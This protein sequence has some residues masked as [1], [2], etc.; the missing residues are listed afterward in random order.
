MKKDAL[1]SKE[2]N[3]E[4]L[5]IKVMVKL[6]CRDHH[7]CQSPPCVA[8]SELIDYAIAKVKQCPLKE[9][10]TTC[11]KCKIHCYNP[12]MKKQIKEVMHYAGPRMLKSHPLLTA[13]HILKGIKKK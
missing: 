7:N 5:T 13:K 3:T 12:A 2:F 6:Y 9:K 11:G 10:R 1:Y 8:C 4:G